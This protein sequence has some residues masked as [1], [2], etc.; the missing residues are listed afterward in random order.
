MARKEEEEQRKPSASVSSME[1]LFLVRNFGLKE[2][3]VVKE[4]HF[5]RKKFS[6]AANLF[7]H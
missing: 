1:I 7:I 2:L 3:N 6:W 5:V 4:A